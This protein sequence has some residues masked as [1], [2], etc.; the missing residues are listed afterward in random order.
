M[1]DLTVVHL[2]KLVSTWL[3]NQTDKGDNH[4]VFS[5]I[6]VM[7]VLSLHI[8]SINSMIGKFIGTSFLAIPTTFEA[9]WTL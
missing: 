9:V 6:Y 3:Y 1:Q 7:S 8:E 2:N 4:C 5:Y